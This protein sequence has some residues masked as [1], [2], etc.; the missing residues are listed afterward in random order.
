VVTDERFITSETERD[1]GMRRI[2]LYMTMT[3]DGFL[4]GPRDELDWF[5]PGRDDETNADVLGILGSADSLMMGYPTA[6]GM[7]AYWKGV[8]EKKRSPRWMLDIARAMEGKHVFVV[9]NEDEDLEL[10]DGE[11]LVTKNDAELTSAVKKLKES[12]GGDI[13]VLGGVRTAQKMS[14]LGLIDEYVLMIHPVAIAKGKPLFISKARLKLVSSKSYR[15]GASQMR[16]RPART[17][18]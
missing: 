17:R 3:L 11:L 14:R 4:S 15:S 10:E 1:E 7:M 2:F 9:S 18:E 12:S 8:G 13:C 16:Y 5:E 6:P